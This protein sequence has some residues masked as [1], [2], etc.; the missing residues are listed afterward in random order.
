MQLCGSVG[1]VRIM[2]KDAEVAKYDK[3]ANGSNIINV[4]YV[5]VG[6]IW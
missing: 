1:S 2:C 6:C 4:G 3:R 5:E